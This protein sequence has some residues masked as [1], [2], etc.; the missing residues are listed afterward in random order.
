MISGGAYKESVST[1]CLGRYELLLRRLSV[2]TLQN[3]EKISLSESLQNVPPS[4]GGEVN[5]CG[6]HNFEVKRVNYTHGG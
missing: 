1:F 2:E 3:V 6:I 5:E 4:G